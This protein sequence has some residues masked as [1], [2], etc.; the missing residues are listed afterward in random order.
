M[1][2]LFI[3]M[4]SGLMLACGSTVVKKTTAPTGPPWMQLKKV[5]RDKYVNVYKCPLATKVMTMGLKWKLSKTDNATNPRKAPTPNR[6]VEKRDDGKEVLYIQYRK[7]KSGTRV[8]ELAIYYVRGMQF[9][10][11]DYNI[12]YAIR[13]G[14]ITEKQAAENFG[15]TMKLATGKYF[16]LLMN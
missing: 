15:T 13:S 8:N 12:V 7:T 6:W 1:R 16:C 5:E 14:K 4:L 10:L 3:L 9:L 2:T 11:A